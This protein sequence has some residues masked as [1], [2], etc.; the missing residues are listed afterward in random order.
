MIQE[1]KRRRSFRNSW[2]WMLLA[3]SFIFV[4]V[5]LMKISTRPA[6]KAEAAVS[7]K[8]QSSVHQDTVVYSI[9]S[10]TQRTFSQAPASKNVSAL[11]VDTPSSDN[12]I[13]CHTDKDQLKALAEEPEKV[14][15]T[16]ASGEG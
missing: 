16:E 12:C 9:T 7:L 8:T 15:S 13:S 4:I 10:H 2:L 14:K 11:L 6:L 1:H 3:L 5:V